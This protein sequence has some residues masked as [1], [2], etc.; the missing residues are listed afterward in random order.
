MPANAAEVSGLGDAVLLPVAIRP[1][2]T[3]EVSNQI[4]DFTGQMETTLVIP[5]GVLDL[6]TV[7][8][9]LSRSVAGSLLT[10][11]DYLTGYPYGCVE[12]TMSR[13]LPN[14]VVGRAFNQLGEA[15]PTL[16]ADLPPKIK[17]GLQRL[18]G[19]QHSDGGWGWWFDDNTHD[20]QTA[21]VVFGLA[22]TAEAGYEVD[23]GVIERGA[24]WLVSNLESM[25]IRT[26][27]YALYSLAYSGHGELEATRALS[28]RVFELD[29]FSQAALVLALHRL[30]DSRRA[31]DIID[32]LAE[33]AIQR[34]GYVY[35]PNP[36]EDGHYYSKTMASTVR[37]TAMALDA[38]VLVR[39]DHPLAGG[40]VRWLM[41]Q[42][43]QE[44]WG[45]T[46]ETS[47]AILALT[48]HLLAQEAVTSDTP[49]QIVL[50]GEVITSGMLGRG[51]PV[52]DLSLP[53]S[54]IGPGAPHQ[55][56]VSTNEDARL[57]Y[58]IHSRMLFPYES[59]EALGGVQVS[60]LYKVYQD[61]MTGEQVTSVAAGQLVLVELT[62][63]LPD[64]GFFLILED[65]LP[66]GLQA[67][68]EHLNTTSHEA[69]LFGEDPYLHWQDYHYNNKEVFAD[70]VSFF[71]T[72]LDAGTYHY[73]YLARA[74][75]TGSFYA[76]P[77][78]LYAMY[79]LSVWGR[80]SSAFL[81]VLP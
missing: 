19:Y 12:Q 68:N 52:V 16:L 67:L 8:I 72:E 11:L 20:Y 47:Y 29:T 71:I 44:G 30:G 75:Q 21:W 38:F 5:P 22:V 49:Y 27:A 79:D 36:Y 48:D 17:A 37:S 4:G 70:H 51:E 23:P 54:D 35:W 42:R 2:A 25:D 13:A 34:D 40:I 31:L 59:V 9:E 10:G 62:F 33:S 41:S 45:S 24:N 81:I 76:L 53:V 46:N 28:A 15:N 43:R 61:H 63:T 60:R 7:R 32:V 3:L 77:A 66:G 65:K 73:S 55:L 64:R 78:E 39:P 18:Y 50:D 6:S 80:S 26:R 58:M 74:T 56:V 57:Y 1:R 69:G 14:A